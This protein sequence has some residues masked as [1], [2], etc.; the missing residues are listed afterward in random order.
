MGDRAFAFCIRYWNW[1]G[2]FLSF[3]IL[4]SSVSTLQ[5]RADRETHLS[6]CCFPR[7][8]LKGLLSVVIASASPTSLAVFHDAF[9]QVALE[10]VH[11]ALS[12][13]DNECNLTRAG[14]S[15]ALLDSAQDRRR[16]VIGATAQQ[17]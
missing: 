3:D 14:V 16:A 7:S 6:L 2:V 12:S 17:G 5:L 15:S 1:T 10:W 4:E 8:F 11:V 9:N 13:A